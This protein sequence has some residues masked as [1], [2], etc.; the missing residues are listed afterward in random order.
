[1]VSLGVMGGMVGAAVKLFSRA[2]AL[3][4]R[5]E[6]IVITILIYFTDNAPSPIMDG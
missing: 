6:M 3:H 5:R 1:M 2:Q 4:K